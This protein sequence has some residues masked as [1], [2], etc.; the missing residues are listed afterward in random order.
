MKF[1]AALAPAIIAATLSAAIA[2]D[3]APAPASAAPAAPRAERRPGAPDGQQFRRGAGPD[4][5]QAPFMNARGAGMENAGPQ[6]YLMRL[7]DD[8]EAIAKLDFDPAVTEDIISTFKK[9]DE[10]IA[11]KQGVVGEQQRK[12]AELIQSKASEDEIMAAIE[13]FYKTRTDIA[14]LQTKKVIKINT[15]LTTEQQEKL[16]TVAME[17]MRARRPA[18]AFGEGGAPAN[19]RGGAREGGARPAGAPARGEGR[20]ARPERPAPAQNN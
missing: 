2:Q 10:Q 5:Q 18:G 19:L 3:A 20:P 8:P 12:Q 17:T 9:L 4:G 16:R 6:A 13:A 14:K 15:A 1:N 7:F 11:A